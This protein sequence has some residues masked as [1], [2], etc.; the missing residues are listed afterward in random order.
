MIKYTYKDFIT[1]KERYTK[2]VFIGWMNPSKIVDIR[3]A[4]F[5]RKRS[6]IYIPEYLLSNGS[7]QVIKDIEEV[8]I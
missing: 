4:K 1:G 7:K 5:K 2:G 8:I 3:Y 6:S